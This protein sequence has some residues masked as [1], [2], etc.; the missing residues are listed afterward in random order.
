MSERWEMEKKKKEEKC[1]N[2]LKGEPFRHSN[3]DRVPRQEVCLTICSLSAP[4]IPF[5]T[6]LS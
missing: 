6:K 2:K 3:L 1:T 5:I 4:K